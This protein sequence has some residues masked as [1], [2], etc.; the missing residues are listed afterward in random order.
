ML[1]A[2]CHPRR[3]A[4]LYKLQNEI[5]DSAPSLYICPRDAKAIGKSYAAALWGL[6]TE[7]DIPQMLDNDTIYIYIYIYI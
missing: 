2:D 7:V 6:C 1:I 4:V 3:H 5:E